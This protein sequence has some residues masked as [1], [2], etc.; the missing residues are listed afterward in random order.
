MTI[1]WEE[2]PSLGLR[3]VRLLTQQ[4]DAEIEVNS[5]KNEGTSFC[6]DFA[7]IN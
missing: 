2:S 5:A 7:P 3:L 6:L 4:L 1:N